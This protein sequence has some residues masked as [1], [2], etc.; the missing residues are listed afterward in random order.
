MARRGIS[1][2]I[3]ALSSLMLVVVLG[4]LLIINKRTTIPT[5]E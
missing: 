3:N 2:T 1:P 4:L 5:K